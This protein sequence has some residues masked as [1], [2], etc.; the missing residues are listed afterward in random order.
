MMP[1]VTINL[2]AGRSNEQKKQLMLDI[3]DAVM[4]NCN[5]PADAVVVQINEAAL[6]NKMK[7]GKT[8]EER[9]KK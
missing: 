3:T 1:E 6:I 9:L 5:V 4:K 7:G 8:F 2:A